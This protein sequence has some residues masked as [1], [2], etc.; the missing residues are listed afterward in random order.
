MSKEKKEIR[1][2]ERV[3]GQ[4]LKNI[5]K[6]KKASLN[7]IAA[8]IGVTFQ[9]VQKYETGENRLSAGKLWYLAQQLGISPSDF[10]PGET[11]CHTPREREIIESFRKLRTSAQTDKLIEIVNL[12]SEGATD[13]SQLEVA[14]VIS[15]SLAQ[16]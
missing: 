16:E 9:Q 6:E 2:L 12:L 15:M 13:Q 7:L 10:F 5:R 14:E 8:M 11:D 4:T 1:A 3:I